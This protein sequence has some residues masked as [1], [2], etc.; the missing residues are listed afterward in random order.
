M[1]ISDCS[2]DVCSSD[3]TLVPTSAN[4]PYDMKELIAKIVDDGDFF[5]LQP[6]YAGNIVTGFG[7]VGGSPVGI[8]ANQPMVLPACLRID[9]ARQP[10][11]FVRSC[12]CFNILLVASVAFPAFLPAP[13]PENDAIHN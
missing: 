9:S 5:E 3:L 4:K 11:R 13:T 6:N 12:D 8:V 7:R 2:S 1:R 10:G